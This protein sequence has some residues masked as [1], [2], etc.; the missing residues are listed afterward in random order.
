MPS[1]RGK[2][3]A[4]LA[5]LTVLLGVASGLAPAV[6]QNRAGS[7]AQVRAAPPTSTAPAAM[8]DYVIRAGDTLIDIGERLFARPENWRQVQTI[9]RIA[10]PY[11]LRIGS[12]LRIPTA[13][14][15]VQAAGGRIVAFQGRASVLRNGSSLTP[16]LDQSLVEGDVLE[17]GPNAYLR[18]VLGD[19]EPASSTHNSIKGA[20][21]LAPT[22]IYHLE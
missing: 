10:D 18:L 7:Q 5:A 14:L 21:F 11:R 20:D 15:R 8:T 22:L 17:T 3:R 9:N 19:L 4:A 12:V 16:R 6:A 2:R 13:F 1:L